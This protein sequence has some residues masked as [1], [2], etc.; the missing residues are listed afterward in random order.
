MVSPGDPAPPATGRG[1]SV[2]A[3]IVHFR[4]RD[5]L[6]RCVE[7]CLAADR[8][9]EVIVVDNEGVGDELGARFPEPRVAVVDMPDNAGYGIA[10]NVG[11]ARA[12]SE[13]VLVLN[14]DVVLPPETLEEMLRVGAEAD[15]WIVAPRLHDLDGVERSRKVAFPPPLSWTPPPSLGDDWH[16]APYVAGAVM[17]LMPGHT[18]LRFDERFF[19][20]GE[21]EDIC[22]RVWAA[23]GRVVVVERAW[24]LHVGAT[25][26]ASVWSERRTARRILVARGRFVRKHAGWN[27]VL[28][29]AW[30]VG[31]SILGART[32]HA[33]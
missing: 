12:R 1:V 13:S 3:V 18:D 15:A 6:D 25:A 23:G 11:I 27:G 9:A 33:R 24:A 8:V 21:D 2:T 22:F 16:P 10:A 20:Y 17:L 14:Q 30:G 7:A 26:T 19:M 32:G 4:G 5:H 29:W 31:A 28:R